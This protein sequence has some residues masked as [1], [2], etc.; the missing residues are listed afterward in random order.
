MLT[1]GGLNSSEYLKGPGIDMNLLSYIEDL[2][3]VL[4]G[5]AVQ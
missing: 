3:A 4:N 5:K 2:K 1:H